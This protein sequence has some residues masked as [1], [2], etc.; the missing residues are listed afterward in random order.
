MVPEYSCTTFIL[1]IFFKFE[2][3][4]KYSKNK[5]EQQQTNK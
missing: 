5:H 1:Q 4:F 2:T 3:I